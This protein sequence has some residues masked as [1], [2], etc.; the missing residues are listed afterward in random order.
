MVCKIKEGTF[1]SRLRRINRKWIRIMPLSLILIMLL[2]PSVIGAVPA[3]MERTIPFS[4]GERVTYEGRWGIIPAGEVTL[5]VLPKETIR[6]IEA[7]HFAMITKTNSAVDLIYKI[8]ERQDSYVA[9]D[10][11]RSILYK[12]KTESKH[13]RDVVV[14]FDWN[15]QES[16]YTN[17]GQSSAPVHIVAGTFDPLALFFILRLQNLTENSV[18]EIP[19]SDGSTNYRVKATIG[20][21]S[22]IDIEGKQYP[23][24]EVAPDMER[25]EGIV[26][27]NE[28]PQLKIW[29]SADE[30]K[31]PLKIQSQV[32]IVSF[33]FEFSSMAP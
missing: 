8:R 2:A 5:E 27:K 33:I 24:I 25:L 18:I 6:G 28:N 19:I 26:K 1:I 13:P 16:T 4:P 31:I 9:A 21:R 23:S 32:G 11:S 22:I 15:K 14:N 7:Y 12:K 3:V 29:F 10:M 30:K 20:K 17:F